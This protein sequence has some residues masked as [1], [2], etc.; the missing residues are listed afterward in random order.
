M[1]TIIKTIATLML[2]KLSL[3]A[4]EPD[5]QKVRIVELSTK[6]PASPSTMTVKG[7]R[8]WHKD[9]GMRNCGWIKEYS[10]DLNGDK[11]P[12]LFLAIDGFGR[13]A[14]YAIFTKINGSWKPLGTTSFGSLCVLVLPAKNKGWHD[15]VAF[16]PTGRGGI[17]GTTYSW[18]GNIY[19]EKESKEF[20]KKWLDEDLVLPDFERK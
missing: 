15:F 17:V 6:V 3:V 10:E 2:F 20:P 18:D 1:K 7:I 19:V 8:Q 13:G 16:C 5:E 14:D 11:N 4:A 9:G 12:E